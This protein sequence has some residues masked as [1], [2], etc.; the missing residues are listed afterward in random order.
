MFQKRQLA[1][2]TV[3]T[4]F[5]LII[6]FGINFFLT[7]Y[8]VR[9]LGSTT[10][11]FWGLANNIINYAL[12][13]TTA[14]NSMA[15]RYIGID[16]H[17]GNLA[18]ASG[19]FSSV[20]H[21]NLIFALILLLPSCIGIWFID[22]LID[23]PPDIVD[24]V[25][26]LFYV[27]FINMCCNIIFAVFG[28]VYV[29]KD[30]LDISSVVSIVSNV[31]KSLM[32][33]YLYWKLRPSI[34]YLGT[35]TL[36]ATV[37]FAI[38]NMFFKKRLVP[39]LKLRFENSSFTSVKTIVSSGIW[40][41]LNQLSMI[42]LQGLDLLIAN[43]FV[44]AAAMGLISVAGMVPAVI[45]T[46]IFALAHVFS[47]RFLKLYSL[48]KFDDLFKDLRNSIK[49]LTVFSSI[50]ITFLISFGLPF[51]RLW[52]PTT[53]FTTVYYL[54]IL[55]IL[56]LFSGGSIIST[57]YL[58]TVADKVKWQA[59]ILFFA[60]LM[61]III[62]LVLLKTTNLGVYA[63]VGVSAVMGF[64]RNFF[65]NAPLGAHCV[66]KKYSALWPDM[67]KSYLC[68][69]VSILICSTINHFFDLNTWTK[70]IVIGG[71]ATLFSAYVISLMLLTSSQRT[72]LFTRIKSIF[73]KKGLYANNR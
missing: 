1:I 59:L 69:A 17:R 70:L 73:L 35:A 68:L 49:F 7:S 33:V 36:C 14:L 21:A 37:F 24:D 11:G 64:I 28:C 54:S 38:S 18:K 25:K 26:L 63:I 16:Y 23:I 8:L 30:R 66:H 15:G 31:I 72:M 65:F 6:N 56:P 60:G 32:L 46:C 40:N 22:S 19:Y 55:V 67:F 53:D 58:Y 47:P 13:I 57:H 39:E 41:S 50:P 52:T 43:L 2:N 62:V 29:I 3:A 9:V 4:G 27:V 45:T 42:L 48:N 12:I 34:V 61:N 51:Y 10:F 20:F 44:G 71:G 5:N